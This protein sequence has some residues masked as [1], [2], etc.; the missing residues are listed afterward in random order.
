MKFIKTVRT[1]TIAVLFSA[2]SFCSF[3]NAKLPDKTN[4]IIEHLQ[5][6]GYNTTINNDAILAKSDKGDLTILPLEKGFMIAKIFVVKKNIKKDVEFYKFVQDLQFF[7]SI[8]VVFHNNDIGFII[9]SLVPYNKETFN[10]MIN[11][12]D[13]YFENIVSKKDLKEK[14]LKYIE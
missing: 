3:A 14:T 9:Y 12:F 6:L 11:E 4:E 2:L 10:F 13:S 8:K 5:F 1:V 7:D